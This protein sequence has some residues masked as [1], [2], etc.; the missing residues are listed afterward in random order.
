MGYL[1]F[2]SK[3][4]LFNAKNSSVLVPYGVSIFLF[5]VTICLRLYLYI[6]LVP[7]GVS[8]FLFKWQVVQTVALNMRSRPLW[9]IYISIQKVVPAKDVTFSSRPLWGIYISIQG[10]F[11]SC[12]YRQSW[13]SSPM[14]YLYFYSLSSLSLICKGLILYFAVQNIFLDLSDLFY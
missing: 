1:Y 13:F 14:G 2:Y 4:D 5:Y 8:I 3:K 12:Y 11:Q 6:V 7:Y 9:G 10:F